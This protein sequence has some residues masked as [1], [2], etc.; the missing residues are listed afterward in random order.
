MGLVLY[1]EVGCTGTSKE[2]KDS[3]VNLSKVGV[4]FSVKAATVDGNP[5]VLYSEE[6][7]QTFLAY[8]EEGRYEDLSSI[9]L[10]ADYKEQI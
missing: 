4:K 1:S 6:R 5:W 3:E 2:I 7:F 9:G 10:P 8:L